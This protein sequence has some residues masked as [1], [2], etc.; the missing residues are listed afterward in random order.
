MNR[1][2]LS[3]RNP[4]WK[5]LLCL[6]LIL[7]ILLFGIFF[8]WMNPAFETVDDVGMMLTSSG[9]RT[10]EP[11]EY[12]TFPSVVIGKILKHL[13]LQVPRINWYPVYLYSIHFLSMLVILYAILKLR[14]SWSRIFQYVVLFIF[15]ECS[16]LMRLQFTSTAIVIAI[17]GFCL[18]LTSLSLKDKEVW[19]YLGV[20]IVMMVTA[21]LIREKVFYYF[22]LLIAPLVLLKFFEA[23]KL[24]IP[25][26][27]ALT[28]SLFFIFVQY[29]SSY[30]SGDPLWKE[31]IAYNKIRG[32]LH[33]YPK[34]AYNEHTKP[35]F[36]K[37]GW[38]E[39]D[40]LMFQNVFFPDKKVYSSENLTFINESLKN[41]RG[42][43]ETL[44][45]LL[46]IIY[47]NVLLVAVSFIF[48]SLSLQWADKSERKFIYCILVTIIVMFI[49]LSFAARLPFRIFMP[50]LLFFNTM[51]L[52]VHKDFQF[53]VFKEGKPTKKRM[54][55]AALLL[56]VFLLLPLH[57]LIL[58][59]QGKANQEKY[60]S[61]KNGLQLLSAGKDKLYIVWGSD[62]MNLQDTSP[63]S[64][65]KEFS[66]LNFVFA[67]R[68][69]DPFNK[70]ILANFGVENVYLSFTRETNI[71]LIM[72]NDLMYKDMLS[73]FIMEHFQKSVEFIVVD[74]YKNMGIYKMAV[75]N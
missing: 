47:Q 14:F 50:T 66:N 26:F 20:S 65:L 61:M 33:L 32:Q 7:N 38:S 54:S 53:S 25:I 9:V 45:V 11:S 59:N 57:L 30:Y 15:F 49:Y 44:T 12:L 60:L 21:G 72:Y 6:S 17:A 69:H 2:F 3:L 10:G 39:N 48:L 37:I 29:N 8:L 55:I 16:L 51:F 58:Y 63:F 70:R 22:L 31:F 23:K 34:L 13:Y 67:G 28:L 73:K 43:K 52:F 18:F 24:R 5:E 19:F 40:F 41:Q 68:L 75:A 36:N 1:I 74:K 4:S 42:L 35:T 64:D 46:Y 27:F 62:A 71:F 56:V